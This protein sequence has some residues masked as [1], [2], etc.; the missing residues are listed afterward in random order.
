MGRRFLLDGAHN[1][2]AIR[3]LVS[4][5]VGAKAMKRVVVFGAQVEKDW[6][7]LLY[8][9]AEVPGLAMVI[10]I[11]TTTGRPV[12]AEILR[13]WAC[14]HG[15]RSL[16]FRGMLS[17]LNYALSLDCDEYLVTGSFKLFRDFDLALHYLGFGAAAVPMEDID[18]AQPWM[19]KLC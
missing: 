3:R 7:A 12:N 17:G 14:A 10:C 18:P 8:L 9:L 11:E 5:L 6:R 2:E 4:R 16:A 13:L 15:I 19:R 1:V